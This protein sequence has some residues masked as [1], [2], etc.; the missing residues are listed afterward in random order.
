LA[1]LLAYY[2]GDYYSNYD[3]YIH[4]IITPLSTMALMNSGN[5]VPT[6]WSLADQKNGAKIVKKTM[7]FVDVGT[8]SISYIASHDKTGIISTSLPL[9]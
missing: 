4:I 9:S 5:P 6:L 7:I 1:D 8:C 2:N 3:T